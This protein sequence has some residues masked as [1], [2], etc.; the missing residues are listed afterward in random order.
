MKR[1]GKT[2]AALLLCAMMLSGVLP[3]TLPAAKAIPAGDG[4]A[5]NPYLIENADDLKQF[6][7][8]VNQYGR[9]FSAKLTASRIRS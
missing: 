5:E 2:L 4:S 1:Y 8:I 7:N 3:G 9:T 6:R